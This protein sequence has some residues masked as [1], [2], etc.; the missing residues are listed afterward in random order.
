MGSIHP[1]EVCQYYMEKLKYIKDLYSIQMEECGVENRISEEPAL[2]W[3]AKHVLNK[4]HLIISKMQQYWVKPHKYGLRVPKTVKE[5]VK[6][7][8]ENAYTLQW[9][10]IIQ[11]MKNV[12]PEFEAWEK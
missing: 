9:D 8:Q 7:D 3:W 5:P 10:A 2:L 1:M 11:E 12:R 4:R 6:I